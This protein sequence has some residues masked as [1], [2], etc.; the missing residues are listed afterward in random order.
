M[1]F[2]WAAIHRVELQAAW[3]ELRAGRIPA[4]IA[5]LDYSMKYLNQKLA[6]MEPAPGYRVRMEFADGFKAELDLSPLLNEGPFF[7]PLRDPI[8]FGGVEL[9]RGVPVWSDEVDLSP[10]ALR[11]WAEAGRVLSIDET[12]EWV[13]RNSH[14]AADV[15]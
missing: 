10:G 4:K 9:H 15:A 5:P 7:A 14:P 2:A 12:D 11:A 1:V 8:F 6:K 3:N 13:A